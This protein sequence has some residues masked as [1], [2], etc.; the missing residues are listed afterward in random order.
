MK[1]DKYILVLDTETIDLQKS[2]N[3]DIG[4][5]VAELKNGLYYTLETK[6]LIIK[7]VFN[8]KE[9]FE[10]A[11]YNNKLKKYRD[12]IY[13]KTAEL[14]GLKDAYDT[15]DKVI[16]KYEIKKVYAYNSEFDKKVFIFNSKF[17]GIGTLINGIE[18]V[19]IMAIANKFYHKSKQF[20]DFV[21]DNDL[22]PKNGYMPTN[23]EIT[24]SALINNPKYKEEHTGIEDCKIELMILNECIKL[25]YINSEIVYKKQFIKSDKIQIFELK[26]NGEIVKIEYRTMRK[27][28]NGISLS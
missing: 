9:L 19:D 15:I 25:G 12:A 11:Y 3:Y 23:A 8:N 20:I 10:T 22:T 7:E 4:Y 6:H 28:K 1:L 21:N 18:W 13:Y 17:Y 24:Y 16:T 27:T 2:F 5:I 26:V 14:V